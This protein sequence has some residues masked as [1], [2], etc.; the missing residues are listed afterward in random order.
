MGGRVV[1]CARLESVCSSMYRGLE[2][3]PLRVD[4][5]FSGSKKTENRYQMNKAS[6]GTTPIWIAALLAGGFLCY[7][8]AFAQVRQGYRARSYPTKR[9]FFYD[10]AY[11]GVHSPL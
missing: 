6:H 8:I 2:S 9:V 1:D 11:I 10:H 4:L 3:P 7:I 5:G